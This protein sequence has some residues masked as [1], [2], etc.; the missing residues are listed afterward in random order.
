VPRL[1]ADAAAA[2]AAAG[3]VPHEGTTPELVPPARLCGLAPAEPVFR[4]PAPHSV[5]PL[6]SCRSLLCTLRPVGAT[7]S[8][9]VDGTQRCGQIRR[10]RK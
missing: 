2:C 7:L 3:R 10:V 6:P 4:T 1:Q 8:L 9:T 5:A